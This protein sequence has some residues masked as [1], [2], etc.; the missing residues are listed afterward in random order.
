[1]MSVSL[2]KLSKVRPSALRVLVFV[3]SLFIVSGCQLIKSNEQA[4]IQELAALHLNDHMADPRA[5]PRPVI[6]IPGILGSRLKNP[7]TGTV[8]WGKFGFGGVSWPLTGDMLINTSLP[9]KHG[10]SFEAFQDD[11]VVDG[12][13]HDLPFYFLPYMPFGIDVYHEMVIKLE[14]LG[15]CQLQ[16]CAENL[17][18]I[19]NKSNLSL[20]EEFSY[21]WRLSNAHNAGLLKK[22]I[23][24]YSID[25]AK[26]RG[27]DSDNDDTI[28]FDIV[29]HSMGCLLARYFLRYGDQPLPQ[30]GKS[31]PT[32]DWSGSKR[33][34]NL[35]MVAP[36][37]AGS[38]R[39]VQT[40]RHGYHKLGF[41]YSSTILATMPSLYELLPRHRHQPIINEE[42]VALDPLNILLWEE[43]QWGP[44]SFEEDAT[45]RILLPNIRSRE[46]RLALMKARMK[47][48]MTVAS[49][50]QRS[51]D[52]E[53]DPPP[54]LKL[55]LFA[56]QS[57]QTPSRLRK[58]VYGDWILHKELLGDGVVLSKSALLIDSHHVKPATSTARTSIS[59]SGV[60]FLF[61]G[62]L[63]L[64]KNHEFIVNLDYILREG[65]WQ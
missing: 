24:Q 12:V 50:F 54:G 3:V 22:F 29:C 41:G 18:S 61:S 30:D 64:T 52:L 46:E 20:I 21:D 63:G 15:Y 59:W 35:V 47:K 45:L 36:P 8:V 44:F 42:G 26:D 49:Q 58:D 48:N 23:D 60:V 4:L 38:L 55:W 65:Q 25:I 5:K 51:M 43:N 31:L 7:D 56:G 39:A 19:D 32:L 28:D 33:V 6:V 27:L 53:A 10:S 14:S 2:E 16:S 11:L 34:K 1:M 40:L 13:V 9:I 57:Q 17:G 62:H 37:N